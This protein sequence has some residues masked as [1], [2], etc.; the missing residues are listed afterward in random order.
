MAQL[1][2]TIPDIQIPRV[3]DAYRHLLVEGDVVDLESPTGLEIKAKLE[4]ITR[5][6]I[7]DMVL[8]YEHQKAI[9]DFIFEDINIT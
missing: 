8:R 2:I 3:I 1:I 4:A 6:R 7:E 5:Q 9:D